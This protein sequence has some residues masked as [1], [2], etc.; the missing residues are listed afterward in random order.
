[1]HAERAQQVHHHLN[2]G[3]S[4]IYLFDDGSRPLLSQQIRREIRG[5]LVTY[6]HMAR[7]PGYAPQLFVYDACLVFSS[8]KYDWVAFIDTDEVRHGCS[9]GR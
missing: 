4:H 5:G 7:H 6:H 1:M 8:Q 3:V 9:M 2:V